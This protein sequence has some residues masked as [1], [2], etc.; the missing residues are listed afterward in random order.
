MLKVENLSIE[1]DGKSIVENSSFFIPRGKITSIIGESG[2]GKS[3]TIA[4]ILG[5]LPFGARTTGNIILDE[6]NVLDL[7]PIE[8]N[9]IR[10]SQVFTIF[11]DA[12]NSFNPSV[13][14]GRQL[15]EFSGRRTKNTP[16]EFRMKMNG[17]LKSLGLPLTIYEQYPFELS[18]GM[19]QRC[20][21][22]CALYV[23]TGL[24]IADEP[25]SAIDVVLQKEFIELLRRIN[26]EHGTTILLITHDLEIAEEMADELVIMRKGKV[27]ETGLVAEV[28]QEPKHVYTKHLLE[29][30]F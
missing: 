22:A 27:V 11:Q 23:Q 12:S 18:G 15:F 14:M 6:K 8:M 9:A 25:T 29:S 19:L 16:D 26:E 24:L 7:S 13:K 17:L 3:M 30:R 10:Q 4:A 21:I 1:L 20:M 2:S 28:F 5:I